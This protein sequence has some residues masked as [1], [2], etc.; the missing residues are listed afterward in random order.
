MSFFD[1]EIEEDI[2]KRDEISRELFWAKAKPPKSRRSGAAVF[3]AVFAILLC[4]FAA[5]VI[6]LNFVLGNGWFSNAIKNDNGVKL[7]I[8]EHQ[9]PE[10]SGEYKTAD[11]RYT[12][13][14]VAQLASQSI[15]SIT[16]YKENDSSED[17]YTYA[18]Q[19][20]GVIF[21]SD[22]Y[23]ITNAHVVASATKGLRVTTS[24][25]SDYEAK[26]IGA[27]DD[28]DI[29]VIKVSGKFTPIEIGDS[30]Q[31]NLGE[32]VVAIGNPGGYG[33]TVTSGIVSGIDR[34]VRGGSQGIKMSCLQI[35]AA[36]NPGSSGGALL[37]MWGQLIGITSSKLSNTKY[38]GIGFAISTNAAIPI[39]ESII[40]NG[41][42]ADRAKLGITYYAVSESQAEIYDIKAGLVVQNVDESC[43]AAKYLKSGDIILELDG[44]TVDRTDDVVKIMEAKKAGQTIKIKYFRYS[45]DGADGETL[46]AECVLMN[47]IGASF[48]EE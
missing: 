7:T 48:T 4:L 42:V 26:V 10:I 28:S 29:A 35:D 27:D 44:K 38:E 32:E 14:G 22:G 36:I 31:T 43:D 41:Y 15:V 8:T 45:D 25:G 37:N 23:I 16:G 5:S 1:D 33:G 6:T 24:D 39:V 47:D 19:G 20:S 46:E 9:K 11:G 2:N 40:E 12:V 34:M 30:T 18:G 3:A 17:P 13:E 21:T